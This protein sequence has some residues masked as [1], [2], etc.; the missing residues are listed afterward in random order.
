MNATRAWSAMVFPITECEEYPG[1]AMSPFDIY[2]GESVDYDATWGG[3][4]DSYYEYLIKAYLT[5]PN[6]VTR[7]YKDR[8]V[9]ALDTAMRKLA[10]MM[11]GPNNTVSHHSKLLQEVH[12]GKLSNQMGHLTCF[13]AGNF[14]L[15]GR[16]LDRQD[17]LDFGLQLLM[18]CHDVYQM[19]PSGIGPEVWA[20]QSDGVSTAPS[21]G[22]EEVERRKHGWWSVSGKYRLRPEVIE[23]YFYAY[24][25][26]GDAI[27]QDYAWDAFQRI[28]ATC[29]AEFG[30]SEVEDVMTAQGK[31]IDRQE[32]YWLAET[33]KYLWL[34]FADVSILDLDEW[35]LSTVGFPSGLCFVLICRKEA[36]P[37]RRTHMLDQS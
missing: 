31:K 36:H 10:C 19:T 37:I 23:S 25:I 2:S 15:A 9:V 7:H 4:S 18:G 22:R 12:G 5:W 20:W 16:G 29:E 26:T 1:M 11:P 32:S 30:F 27:Y 21:N 8:Y 6:D 14:I 34:I 3:G 13:A 17:V 24:R 35:T 33:L 28:K